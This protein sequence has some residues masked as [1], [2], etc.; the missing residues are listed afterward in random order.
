MNL[1]TPWPSQFSIIGTFSLYCV[2]YLLV[3]KMFF[4]LISNL[5]S[6]WHLSATFQSNVGCLSLGPPDL[7]ITCIGL[8]LLTGLSAPLTAIIAVLTALIAA[9]IIAYVMLCSMTI[10]GLPFLET[11]LC[12]SVCFVK[13]SLPCVRFL[14]FTSDI[15]CYLHSGMITPLVAS[16]S[17]I[18]H[19]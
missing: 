3:M 17:F 8:A 2:L 14:P 18:Q 15:M 6:S 5:Y 16:M 13:L 4:T 7:G 1:S 9:C 12:E 19:T 11:A 10:F